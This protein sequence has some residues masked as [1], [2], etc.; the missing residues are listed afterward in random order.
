VI[1]E[2]AKKILKHKDLTTVTKCMWNVKKKVMPITTAT[3]KKQRTFGKKSLENSLL[4]QKPVPPKS[5]Y[6][7]ETNI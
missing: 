6:G 1:K 2:E 4:D 7:K 3:K 5:Q